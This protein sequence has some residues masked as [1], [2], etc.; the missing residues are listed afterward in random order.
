MNQFHFLHPNFYQLQL[1][2]PT[3]YVALSTSILFYLSKLIPTFHPSIFSLL[4]LMRTL[5][6][7]LNQFVYVCARL[8]KQMVIGSI[9]LHLL[10]SE[11]PLLH[12][13]RPPLLSNHIGLICSPS[14]FKHF[15]SFN[16]SITPLTPAATPTSLPL[17][18]F[19]QHFPLLIHCPYRSL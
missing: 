15:F 6:L 17:F 10:K 14:S 7:F 18:T 11:Y 19:T 1:S 16:L 3:L 13:S 4:I 12:A 2:F 8:F 5:H 9:R